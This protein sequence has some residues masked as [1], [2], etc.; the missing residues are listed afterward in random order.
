MGSSSLFRNG[1]LK[2]SFSKFQKNNSANVLN[3]DI[4]VN[5]IKVESDLEINSMETSVAKINNGIS[6]VE[7][8]ITENKRRRSISRSRSK[9][10]IKSSALSN[11]SNTTTPA[12]SSNRNGYIP[13]KTPKKSFP[14]K[15]L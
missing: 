15:E 12:H 10:D 4:A 3:K 2:G 7:N 8:V 9:T 11:R 13:G 6:S 1:K 5:I 14:V